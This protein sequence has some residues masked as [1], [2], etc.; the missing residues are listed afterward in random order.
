M[1]LSTYI[2]QQY[3]DLTQLANTFNA[4]QPT[5]N[6]VIDNFLP[7]DLA[8]D[9][10]NEC[11]SLPSDLWTT[12]TRNSSHMK[13]CRKLDYMPVGRRFVE[14]MTSSS[15][16]TWLE[17]VTGITGLIPDP[18]IV[19]AGYSKSYSGDTLQVHNDFNWNNELRV[20]RAL[21]VILYLTPEW[22]S[23]WGGGLDFYDTNRKNVVKTVDCLFNRLLMWEYSPRN[24]HGYTTPL[25]CPMDVTRNTMRLFYYV[26]NST[27]NENDLP[28]RS[29]Y[30]YNP[31]TNSAYDKREEQ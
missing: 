23:I 31:E 19:G 14:E 17:R 30:W 8:L 29:Q 12:F 18:H 20:H 1:H 15:T 27:Y 25:S 26:S 21:S 13:E 22:N 4:G 28:H 3:S 9:L 5:R 16:I 7:K 10:N 24:F 6:L 11:G 2:N